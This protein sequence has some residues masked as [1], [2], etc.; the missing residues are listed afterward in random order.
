MSS[1]GPEVC[2]RP[3]GK[4][5]GFRAQLE[6]SHVSSHL[7]SCDTTKVCQRMT[8]YIYIYK[9]IYLLCRS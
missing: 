6:A 2:N 7:K 1:H 9:Y 8:I 5:G 4:L 3:D